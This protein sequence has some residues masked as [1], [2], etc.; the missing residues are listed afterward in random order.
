MNYAPRVH[1]FER[2]RN[3]NNPIEDFQLSEVVAFG[4]LALDMVS[5]VA[6]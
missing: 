6:D 4:L 2:E 5:E 1:I 3:L